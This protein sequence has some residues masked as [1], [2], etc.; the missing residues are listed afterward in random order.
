[1]PKYKDDFF[2]EK[3]LKL[4]DKLEECEALSQYL[5]NLS[6]NAICKETGLTVKT[7]S[8]EARNSIR[9][10]KIDDLIIYFNEK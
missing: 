3:T 5:S 4:R 2:L 1:M 9:T 7:F 6:T 8:K 10:I